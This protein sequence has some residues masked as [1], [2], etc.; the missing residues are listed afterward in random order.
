MPYSPDFNPIEQAFAKLKTVLRTVAKRNL[1]GLWAAIGRIIDT[2]TPTECANY[3]AA[4]D[5]GAQT[6]G[7]TLWCA[8]STS[9]WHDA[10]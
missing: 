5:Y 8:W 6:D 10:E 2:L 1:N 3:F 7:K 9:T 4:A